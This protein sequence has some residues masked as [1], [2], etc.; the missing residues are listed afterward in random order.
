MLRTSM[1][2]PGDVGRSSAALDLAGAEAPLQQPL[3]EDTARVHD[4]RAR[5]AAEEPLVAAGDV[6]RLHERLAEVASGK[7]YLLH[8]GECAETFAMSHPDHVRR[9]VA[10][11]RRLASR[12]ATGSGRPVV[13]VTRMAG[14][15]AKPRSSDVEILADG[16]TVPVYRGDAVN[17]L[18]PTPG[19]RRPDP[20][21][22]LSS[23]AHARRTLLAAHGV[24]GDE[25]F[26]VSHEALLRD[27]EEPL[28]RETEH[29]LLAGSGHLL[30]LGERTRQPRRWHVKWASMISN[31]IGVK[32]GPD[33]STDDVAV[34]VGAL[35]P[36]RTPGRLSLITRLGS[37][38]A[39][40]PSLVRAVGGRQVLWQCDPMHGNTR[41]HAGRKV[42]LLPDIHAEVARFVEYLRAAGAH[43]GGLHLEVTPD[44]VQECL[45]SLTQVTQ[46]RP[47]PPCDPRL[48][49][50]QAVAVVDEFA[51][52]VA[53]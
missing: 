33:A 40:L 44:D 53:A 52:A 32:V 42:R 18:T 27:Y 17:S 28:T 47:A 24:P 38:V 25:P 11:Y 6:R 1:S 7:A 16:T 48:N 5:L 31:P 37:R 39:R 3:W 13:L 15:Y 23:M 46:P 2:I 22:L 51:R 4:I 12:L 43:P 29:G 36:G 20:Q 10:L 35:D 8:V 30:W 19:G 45:E 49:T 21:R 50:A 26:H 34:L 9:R 14:Q 41:M